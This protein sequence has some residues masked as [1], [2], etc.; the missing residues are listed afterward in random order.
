MNNSEQYYYVKRMRVLTYLVNLGFTEYEVI[1]DPTSNKGYSW[2][3]FK[4]TPELMK[5]VT[6][7][8]AQ[9]K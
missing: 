2:W 5:A 9:F 1:P 8:F 7:Y 4:K 3:I 6:E